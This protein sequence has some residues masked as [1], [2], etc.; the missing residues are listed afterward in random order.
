LGNTVVVATSLTTVNATLKSLRTI[1]LAVSLGLLAALLLLMTLLIRQGLRPLEAMAKEADAIAAGDLTRR[2]EPTEGDTEIARLG[3]ALNGMLA[4]I[5]A[6]F[7][8]RTMSE[9]RL[10]RFLADAS[11][12]LRTPLTSIRGYAE[13]LRKE[14]FPDEEA[15]ERALARIETEAARMGELVNDLLVLAR[16]GEEPQ[17]TRT[18]VDLAVAVADA[19]AALAVGGDHRVTLEAPTPVMV[20]ADRRRVDQII[21]NLLAN[22]LHHTPDGTRIDVVVAQVGENA[23]LRVRDQGPGMDEEQAGRVFDRFYRGDAARS[24]GGSG[25][26][27]FIVAALSRALGGQVAL[28]TAVG[29]GSTFEVVLPLHGDRTDID[30]G[31]PARAAAP[32]PDQSSPGSHVAD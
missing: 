8:Q 3:R 14:A 15:R 25:L 27:L 30:D 32:S 9:D 12:E 13:L 20:E 23:V 1:E 7:V 31:P 11:H 6:A 10:R 29:E 21:R 2:V 26:G 17:P 24:D 4:Q 19:V 5:E 18:Q 16:L 22:A 28:D